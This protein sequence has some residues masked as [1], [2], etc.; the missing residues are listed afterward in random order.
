VAACLIL[1]ELQEI[2]GLEGGS[3]E[4]FETNL[5]VFVYKLDCNTFI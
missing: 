3:L 1:Q 2:P 5:K 4:N